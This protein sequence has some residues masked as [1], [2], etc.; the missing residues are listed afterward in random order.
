MVT[1]SQAIDSA[2]IAF[3]MLRNRVENKSAFD[4]A[5]EFMRHQ[6]YKACTK[7]GIT[8]NKD[9]NQSRFLDYTWGQDYDSMPHFVFFD[10][11]QG[12]LLNKYWRI[13]HGY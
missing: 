1:F 12:I 10:F 4:E 13:L 5:V 8:R 11:F 7:T 6:K 2:P 3:Y 9:G